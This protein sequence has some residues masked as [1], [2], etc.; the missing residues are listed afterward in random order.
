MEYALARFE[1][2]ELALKQVV[3]T[4]GAAVL[5]LIFVKS[6]LF[7]NLELSLLRNRLQSVALLLLH[8]YS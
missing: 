2:E 3:M 8:L 5:F 1:N 6:L 4:N 7:F